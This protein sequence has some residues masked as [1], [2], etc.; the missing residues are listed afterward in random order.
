MGKCKTLLG[1]A[2]SHRHGGDKLNKPKPD[3]SLATETGHFHLL[4][5]LM[6]TA[7]GDRSRSPECPSAPVR[8]ETSN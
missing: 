3:R 6:Y 7:G 1:F 8:R 4:P 2:L 5:T